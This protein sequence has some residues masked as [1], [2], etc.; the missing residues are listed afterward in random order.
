MKLVL[1]EQIGR[2]GDDRDVARREVAGNID[3]AARH[4]QH[5]EMGVALRIRHCVHEAHLLQVAPEQERADDR[6]LDPGHLE[7]DVDFA[8]IER[9]EHLLAAERQKPRAPLHR[10]AFAQ[11]MQGERSSAAPFGADGHPASGEVREL[12]D[13]RRPA[14]RNIH[15]GS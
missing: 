15:I 3:N 13:L 2:R 12:V 9:A 4:G 7:D 6:R 1:R 11:Q 8:R 5:R 10:T 14:A